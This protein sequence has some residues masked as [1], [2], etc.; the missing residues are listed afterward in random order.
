MDEL[1]YLSGL[2]TFLDR[3]SQVE[4][5][6]MVYPVTRMTLMSLVTVDN[7]EGRPWRVFIATETGWK[8][9]T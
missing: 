1:E 3:D 8:E 5:T 6:K 4:T 2:V 9:Q 7:P